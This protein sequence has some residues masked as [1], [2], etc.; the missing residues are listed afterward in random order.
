MFLGF[1]PSLNSFSSIPFLFL[2][3]FILILSFPLSSLDIL[4]CFPTVTFDYLPFFSGLVEKGGKVFLIYPSLLL[5][6][7]RQLGFISLKNDLV[8]EEKVGTLDEG[9][10]SLFRGWVN[11]VIFFGM[12]DRACVC[13]CMCLWGERRGCKF[14]SKD[15]ILYGH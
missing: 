7:S 11:G 3:L 14:R 10:F 13:V 1:L 5:I 2:F 9:R 4:P 12:G 15:E 6:Q 8:P